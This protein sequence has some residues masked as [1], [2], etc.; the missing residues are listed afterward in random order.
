MPTT[1]TF[2]VL[3]LLSPSAQAAETGVE[4]STFKLKDRDG[5]LQVQVGV[6]NTGTSTSS[7]FY[8]DLF[9]DLTDEPKF[10][11]ISDLYA[12]VPPLDS[13]ESQRVDFF[14]PMPKDG[15]TIY[16]IADTEG[17][18]KDSDTSNNQ[19]GGWLSWE[20]DLRI[21]RVEIEEYGDL[22]DL[23]VHVRNVGNAAAGSF[24]VDGFDDALTPP[25]PGDYG[26]AYAWVSGLEAGA[27]AEVELSVAFTQT[28]QD[29]YLLL[30]TDEWVDERDESNN[31]RQIALTKTCLLE[32]SAQICAISDRIASR[33]DTILLAAG[34]ELTEE[35]YTELLAVL[36]ERAAL[37]SEAISISLA[38][39][40]AADTILPQLD[41]GLQKDVESLDEDGIA[42]RVSHLMEL[43]VVDAVDVWLE[44]YG[45]LDELPNVNE[46]LLHADSGAM[47]DVR[48]Q[49]GGHGDILSDSSMLGDVS[50]TT[51]KGDLIDRVGGF[52]W[53]DTDSLGSDDGFG[54]GMASSGS[55]GRLGHYLDAA[56]KAQ[57]VNEKIVAFG[58]SSHEDQTETVK[59]WLISATGTT[60]DQ[61]PF[62]DGPGTLDA[63]GAN[64]DGSWLSD[65]F[66]AV[67]E[68]VASVL[69]AIIDY[70]WG[71]DDPEEDEEEEEEEEE[72][73]K[74]APK[75]KKAGKKGKKS[76]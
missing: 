72:E 51:A 26:E 19:V 25:E 28:D 9:Q 31:T 49:M 53:A 55:S 17:T 37:S 30:D 60:L 73:P 65:A 68:V 24:Y 14:V 4:I 66:E 33:V 76:G 5:T 40:D 43:M 52:G 62:V 10:G 22:L 41:D 54:Y 34:V 20:A 59:G 67:A 29:I 35:E 12:Y 45:L 38:N 56:N 11:T 69:D 3:G 18:N 44:E 50:L 57:T 47:D 13:G 21:E 75:K 70:F 58:E 1:F 48:D 27:V 42:E 7:G 16:A 15:G 23:V 36:A 8:V 74:P 63:L 61:V 39:P 32:Y 2:L 71:T 64:E 6:A 46:F